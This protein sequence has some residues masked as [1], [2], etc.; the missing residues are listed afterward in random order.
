MGRV[1]WSEAEE[2]CCSQHPDSL[3]QGQHISSSI[4]YIQSNNFFFY[5]FLLLVILKADPAA[6]PDYPQGSGYGRSMVGI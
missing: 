2:S 4:D 5:L 3:R 6:K 1:G